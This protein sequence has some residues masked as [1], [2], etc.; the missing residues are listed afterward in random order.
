MVNS[1]QAPPL[2][3]ELPRPSQPSSL[4]QNPRSLGV[5]L[6]DDDDSQ[7]PGLVLLRGVIGGTGIEIVQASDD[8]TINSTGLPGPTG[9]SGG[10]QGPQ[11]PEGPTGPSG[12]LDLPGLTANQLLGEN[13]AGTD[14]EAKN[15]IAGAGIT[16]NHT[17]NNI[18][19]VN[20]FTPFTN[21]FTLYLDA[22]A[23]NGGD[24]SAGTPWNNFDDVITGLA[25]KPNG[26][27]SLLVFPGSYT[28]STDPYNWPID[29]ATKT[30]NPKGTVGSG[31][32]F[33]FDITMTTPA[34]GTAVVLFDSIACQ[35]VT[36]DT[37]PTTGPGQCFLTFTKG[38]YS[39]MI[40]NGNTSFD[41]YVNLIDTGIGGININSGT[42]N[43]VNCQLI[44]ATLTID[45]AN[46][47][48]NVNGCFFL[49]GSA[50]NLTNLGQLKIADTNGD[51][52]FIT[53][54]A[55]TTIDTD[56]S[57]YQHIDAGYLGTVVINEVC[58]FQGIKDLTTNGSVIVGNSLTA[59][60]SK[61]IF[62]GSSPGSTIIHEVGGL[63]ADVSGYDGIIQIK[64]GSTSNLKTN[65]AATVAPT[66]GD[67]SG[68]GY[69]IGSLWID[70]VAKEAY[71]CVDSTTAVW[72]QITN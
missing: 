9:P 29:T 17:T 25:L 33:A 55:G 51:G 34:G 42:L 53:G 38:I 66:S 44:A 46:S 1:L 43:C 13:S 24:G 16:I 18:E 63:E 3:P 21:A 56:G 35:Q 62:N 7:I 47:S 19:I 61:T 58:G 54:D 37:T 15:I 26:N 45:G 14:F 59:P 4:F 39:P 36:V 72:K 71:I 64:S 67:N 69:S 57:S 11:G 32:S 31:C 50:V 22:T 60:T 48:A 70:T 41:T 6:I 65:F 10:P 28:S 8:I 23:P 68:S 27:Y 40:Y 49:L 20:S 12:I 2:P 5:T 30:L 52:Q